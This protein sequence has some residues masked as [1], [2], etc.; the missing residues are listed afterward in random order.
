MHESEASRTRLSYPVPGPYLDDHQPQETQSI[1]TDG[2]PRSTARA[3]AIGANKQGSPS[4]R[5]IAARSAGNSATSTG[6][7][8]SSKD[9]TCSSG[10]TG[11]QTPKAAAFQDALST[12][13]QI[14]SDRTEHPT[15]SLGKVTNSDCRG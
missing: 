13:D 6:N 4:H 5:S 15:A 8:R 2:R 9:S 10:K 3:A 11:V 14:R 7:P 12:S 1:A